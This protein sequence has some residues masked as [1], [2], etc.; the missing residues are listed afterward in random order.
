MFLS[1]R[2]HTYYLFYFDEVGKRRKVSTHCSHKNDALRFLQDFKAHEHEQKVRLQRMLLSQFK[3]DFL[4]HA[5]SNRAASTQE[6]LEIALRVFID[7]LGDIP[8]HKI[9]VREIEGFLAHK[10][11]DGCSDYTLRFY[12][13]ALASAFETAKRWNCIPA[14]PF[15][16]V[17][18]PKTPE[19]QPPHFTKDEFRTLLQTIGDMDFREFCIC[20]VSTGLRLS[21]LTS[22][23]WTDIDLVWKV[24]HVRNSDT[25]ITKSRK[26]RIVPMNEQLWQLL[27]LRKER[28]SCELVFHT[29]GHRWTKDEVS[30]RFKKYVRQALGL[31]TKLHFHSL[32]HTFAS[33]LVQEG[34]SLYEVQKLLGHSNISVTE[35][36]SHLQ[37]EQLHSTVNR[38]EVS[39]N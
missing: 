36:Y 30:K 12:Y 18:K 33:W 28:A 17:E 35:I 6:V 10:K 32:R 16:L 23:Q 26:N 7:Y 39:L 4:E 2:G 13:I 27:A 38:I 21:E 24:I 25:F 8:L 20:A 9:G 11:G 37:P 15:R 1:K 22:L 3:K 19:L 31:T 29:N 34:V 5:K 14:N